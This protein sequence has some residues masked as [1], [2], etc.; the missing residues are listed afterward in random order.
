VIVT[1]FFAVP[2]LL[3]IKKMRKRLERLC[4]AVINRARGLACISIEGNW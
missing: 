2:P 4:M 1:N 3:F